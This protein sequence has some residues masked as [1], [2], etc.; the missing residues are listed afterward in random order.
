[1]SSA[2]RIE[3]ER[4]EKR[5]RILDAART[6]FLARGVEAV[7]LREIAQRIEYST[8]AIYV[9]FKDKAAL[10]AAMLEE[11]FATFARSLDRMAKVADPVDRLA[12]LHH[13]YIEFA[14]ARPH[15]YQLLFLTPGT[16]A[17]PGAK[18]P[19][20]IDGY[21]TLH[22]TIAACISAGRLRPELADVDAVAQ[23]V[24]AG[25]HGLASLL[26]V[27][28]GKPGFRW[29]DSATLGRM[30]LD[31]TLHGILREPRPKRAKRRRA[32][33]GTPPEGARG[34]SPRGRAAGRR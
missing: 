8:T 10:V 25:V 12:A 26:I 5:A 34:L 19:T 9:H 33:E 6:L 32:G 20:G 7:T 29:R 15:H 11:D 31:V 2:E 14:L 21:R 4:I 18:E 22:S 23:T 24:W 17:Q 3:R 16:D 13:A 30:Q 1:M 27:L 28:G